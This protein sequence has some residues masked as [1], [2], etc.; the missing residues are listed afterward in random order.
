MEKYLTYPL[1]WLASWSGQ[2][3]TP[4]Y[5]NGC[6]SHVFA[7][8]ALSLT[9]SL[10]TPYLAILSVLYGVY[11]EFEDAKFDLKNWNRK[12]WVDILTWEFGCLIGICLKL[13]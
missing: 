1:R 5:R 3:Y 9:L 8:W 12:S 11:R 10:I 13:L 2:E 4:E 6:A 7:G